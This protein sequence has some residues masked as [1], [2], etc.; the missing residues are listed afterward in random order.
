LQFFASLCR[1][2][3]VA[4]LPVPHIVSP[5]PQTQ[6]EPWQADPPTH[7]DPHAPQLALSVV[8]STHAPAQRV[9]PLLHV[10]VHALETHT[11]DALATVVAQAAPQVLQ[12]LAL[13]VRS[14]HVVPQSVGVAAGQPETQ[15]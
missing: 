7:V 10:N 14:T 5:A 3:H 2:T 15:E 12:S 6:F 8:V 11:G 1:L 4:P 9:K 13:L